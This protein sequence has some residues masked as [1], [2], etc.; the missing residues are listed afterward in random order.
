M[1]ERNENQKANANETQSSHSEVETLVAKVKA[2]LNYTMMTWDFQ[3]TLYKLDL[4]PGR[5]S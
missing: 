4:N 3:Y 5:R 2:D 1:W